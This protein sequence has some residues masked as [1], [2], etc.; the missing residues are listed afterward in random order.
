[1][2][3]Y[4]KHILHQA[5]SGASPSSLPRTP[6]LSWSKYLPTSSSQY[7][8]LTAAPR[9]SRSESAPSEDEPH[10]Q[11]GVQSSWHGTAAL[12]IEE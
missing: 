8:D 5:V 6:P 2:A 11:V 3:S 7:D 4:N 12:I 10:S 1:M 9:S